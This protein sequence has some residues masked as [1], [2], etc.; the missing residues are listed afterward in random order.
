[1]NPRDTSDERL[2]AAFRA[3]L[4]A[5]PDPPPGVLARTLAALPVD[6]ARPPDW[7]AMFASPARFATAAAIVVLG[8]TIAF[9]TVKAVHNQSPDAQAS[10]PARITLDRPRPG[11]QVEHRVSLGLAVRDVDATAVRVAALVQTQGGRV[12]ARRARGPATGAGRTIRFELRMRAD[13]LPATLQALKRLGT[14]ETQTAVTADLS[15]ALA[16]TLRRLRLAQAAAQTLRA[17]PASADAAGLRAMQATIATLTARRNSL[18][19]RI[20]TATIAL[21]IRQTGELSLGA[22]RPTGIAFAG[23]SNCVS[24]DPNGARQRLRSLGP[25]ASPPSAARSVAGRTPAAG[26]DRAHRA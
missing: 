21:A 14:L 13:R 9:G 2:A 4:D 12:V 6:P 10:P 17:A 19:E 18:E 1:M 22:P 15:G 5:A 11:P 16:T 3:R 25:P 26:D 20:A 7:R 8:G 23:A 24:H